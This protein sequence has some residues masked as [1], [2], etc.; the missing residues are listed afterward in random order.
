MVQVVSGLLEDS[1]L[2]QTTYFPFRG[3]AERT[4]STAV[5]GQQKSPEELTTDFLSELYKHIMYTL[6]QQV[7]AAVLRTIPL[8]FCL[9]VP[10]IWS[11][12]AKEKTLK[13]CQKAG[14]RSKSEILMVSEPV[15]D[16][17]H[18]Y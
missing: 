18:Q 6:E 4:P 2:T 5:A 8:E 1:N 15:S 3:I 13:A 9:T 10:A 11:E 17:S 14:I 16:E 12:A 7:G